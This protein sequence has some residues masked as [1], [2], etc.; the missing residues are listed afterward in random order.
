M[1]VYDKMLFSM[2]YK[3]I[4][5]KGLKTYSIKDR[6]SKVSIEKSALP[7]EKGK[8]F[9]EFV[10]GLPDFLAA[11]DLKSVA[12]AI[13]EAH[14]NKRPLDQSTNAKIKGSRTEVRRTKLLRSY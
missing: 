9:R 8:S 4:D 7:P 1:I 6:K 11:K 5:I 13:V 3:L 14:K 2:G 10:A 12:R